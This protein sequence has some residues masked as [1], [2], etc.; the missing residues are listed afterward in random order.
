MA[1]RW[2]QW[3]R[4]AAPG[5]ADAGDPGKT[6]LLMVCMG[7]ICRSPIAEGVLRAKL[8]A[9]GMDGQIEVDSAGTHGYH[10]GEPP[11]A[12]A[13]RHAARR[14]YDIAKLRARAVQ[15][16]DFSRFHW[17]LAMDGDN[18]AWLRRQAPAEAAGRTLLLMSLARRHAGI[19]EVP[20]PYYGGPAGF[21]HVLDLVEDACEGLVARLAAGGTA[22]AL[23]S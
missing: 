3:L 2:K 4:G 19:D 1:P 8:R 22:A 9:A 6:R 20:D 11:D 18:L 10:S 12:R 16:Q 5:E 21:E 14:G 23:S 17:L 15:A 13:V 7:N